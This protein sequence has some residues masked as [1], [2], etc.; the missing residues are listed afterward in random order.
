MT[1]EEYVAFAISKIDKD[2]PVSE[3][4]AELELLYDELEKAGHHH[5]EVFAMVN[6]AIT[7]RLS[8]LNKTLD[9][10]TKSDSSGTL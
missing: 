5:T 1:V 6:K 10:L 8:E 7:K 9:D 4:K 2:K 3:W